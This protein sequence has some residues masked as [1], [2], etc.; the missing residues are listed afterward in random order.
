MVASSFRGGPFDHYSPHYDQ[1]AD[2]CWLGRG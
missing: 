2:L 1:L